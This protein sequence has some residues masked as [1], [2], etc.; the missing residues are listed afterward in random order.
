M[1][2]RLSDYG[3]NDWLHARP[4]TQGLKTRRYRAADRAFSAMPPRIAPPPD[5]QGSIK[6]KRVLVTIAFEDPQTIEWQSQLIQLY[7]P[8]VIHIIAD[9]TRDDTQAARI[10]E[11]AAKQNVPY[12]H[13]PANPWNE[14]SR[15]HGLALNWVW[16]NVIHPGAPSMFGLLDDDMYPTAPS[17][18]FAPLATQD[19]FGVVRPEGP[20]GKSTVGLGVTRWFLWAGFAMYRFD[21]VRGKPLDFSQDWFLRLDTGGANWDVLYR[22][23][24]RERIREQETRFVP[25]KD[26]LTVNDAPFQWCGTWL[27]EVGV[28]GRVEFKDDKR[29]VVAA[30][31]A[32]HLEKARAS[33]R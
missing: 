20:A 27:H 18:P 16:R 28:M 24:P 33:A 29:R 15:S 2:P 9:N 21:A 4:L 12:L 19:W 25:Y 32:P 17:D 5:L 31:L 3:L 11:A 8:D 7:V 30:L 26:G 13:L 14:P 1:P 23:V 10:A 22:H 6:G